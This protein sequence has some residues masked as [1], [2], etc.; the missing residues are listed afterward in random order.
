MIRSRAVIAIRMKTMYP[1]TMF[2]DFTQKQQSLRKK[3]YA[4]L[5]TTTRLNYPIFL[6]KFWKSRMAVEAL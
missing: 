5:P 3:T 6:K 2:K 1:E 4:V